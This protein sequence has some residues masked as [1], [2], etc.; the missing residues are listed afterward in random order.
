WVF[1]SQKPQLIGQ[2][3]TEENQRFLTGIAELD[4]VL[5]GGIVAGS[6]VLVGGE[7]GIGKSTLLLQTAGNIATQG[8]P[9]LLVSGE[10]S[11]QQIKMRGQRLGAVADNLYLVSE[12]AVDRIKNRVKELAPK[13][14]I[15]D[16]IQTLYHPDVTSAP[17]S[18]TQVRECTGELLRMAKTLG[19]SVFI[20]GHVTKDGA[21]AGPRLLEHMVDTVLYFEGSNYNSY[22]L[23][24]AIKNRY[25]ATNELAVFE[26]KANGLKSVSNPSAI[27]LAER[28]AE[29]SGSIVVAT[30][31][32]SRPLLVEV[33][34]LVT[35][36]YQ[37]IPR[38]LT[39]GVD[40]NRAL[41]TLA[42]L[43]RRAG[44]HLE[45]EDIYINVVGGIKV[46]EPAID[47]GLALAVASA[48]L[49]KPIS[50]EIAVFGE[51]GLS[52]DIRYVARVDD[53]LQE[54]SKLGFKKIIM[55][56]QDRKSLKTPKGVELLMVKT[57]SEAVKM[58]G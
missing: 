50:P 12:I 37:S 40:F 42:V 31:E 44:F 7:P 43:E 57:L 23:V 8:Q 41:L 58:I 36:T 34:A 19:I 18:V 20:V 22:R 38:R 11:I 28:S 32:G 24:R 45:R 55:S 51:I 4:R 15:I 33:Q 5:G 6:M 10:E 3:K 53:R 47:L 21:I 1:S 46:T 48:H 9:V 30:I 52:G 29:T 49:D 26:M 35:D 2:V 54:A 17:G 13:F 14:L 27:L 16:S 56:F 39:S 25:G